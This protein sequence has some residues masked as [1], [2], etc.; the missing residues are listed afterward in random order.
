MSARPRWRLADVLLGGTLIAAVLLQGFSAVGLALI[1]ISLFVVLGLGLW[2]SYERGL[3]FGGNGISLALAAFWA[4]CLAAAALAVVP[5]VSWPEAFVV[6]SLPLAY[7]CM[8]LAPDQ[9]ATWRLLRATL[10]AVVLGACAVSL[11]QL[12]VELQPV[13]SFFVQQNSQGAFLNLG[14][15]VFAGPLA[16]RADRSVGD[17]RTVALAAL[18]FL[19]MFVVA[20]GLGRGPAIGLGVGLTALVLLSPR[21][22]RG[23]AAVLLV[24]MACAAFSTANLANQGAVSRR[25]ESAAGE[26][27]LT[28]AGG[29]GHRDVGIWQRF[30]IWRASA[31]MLSALPWHGFGPGAFHVVYPGYSPPED[32]SGLQYAHNDYLQF[33]I[34]LGWPGLVLVGTVVGSVAVRLRRALNSGLLEESRR[35]E[36]AGLAGGMA[37][38]AVHSLVSY[39]FQIVPTLVL[40]GLVLARLAW[41]TEPVQRGAVRLPIDA[42]FSRPVFG[43]VVAMGL[44]VPVGVLAA[45]AGTSVLYSQA[46]ADMIAGRLEPAER[47]LQEAA[48]LFDTQQVEYARALLYTEAVK[49]LRDQPQRRGEVYKLALDA[50]ARAGR[51]N[52]FAAD[53][54]YGRGR[55][56]EAAP[57]LSRPRPLARAAQAYRTALAKDPRAFR[58]RMALADLLARGGAPRAALQELADGLAYSYPLDPGILRYVHQT[59][60]MRRALGDPTGAERLAAALPGVEWQLEH[61]ARPWSPAAANGGGVSGAAGR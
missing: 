22:Q 32:S 43:A 46:R 10:A 7:F 52:P 31:P 29:S 25:F 6:G 53:V 50:L 51:L 14:L 45:V 39:N 12:F 20:A 11:Y 36:I 44:A 42:Q 2:Q 26:L 35:S 5:C 38:V 56:F 61:A 47:A 23:R 37:A 30:V 17:L 33:L 24:A 34:E 55:L 13:R 15:L 18:V 3:P 57:T 54:P 9:E 28:L 48:A 21:R 40:F 49:Q 41:L 4:W 1:G 27:R 60:R 19:A 8:R 16:A 58:A 59:I